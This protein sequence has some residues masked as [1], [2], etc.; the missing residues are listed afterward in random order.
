MAARGL[1]VNCYTTVRR[2]GR[3]QEYKPYPRATP[4]QAERYEEWIAIQPCSVEEAA[5]RMGISVNWMSR[6]ARE[7][8]PSR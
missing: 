3:L 8:P 6:I 4:T 7:G 5:R 2:Q 1:C